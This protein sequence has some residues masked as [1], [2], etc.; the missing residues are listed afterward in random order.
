MLPKTDFFNSE[1]IVKEFRRI[2]KRFNVTQ[3]LVNQLTAEYKQIC[4]IS[5]EGRNLNIRTHPILSNHY[6]KDKSE[7]YQI[8][9]FP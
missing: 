5:K 7:K 4:A 8:I 9:H 2:T 6:I 1:I 3:E